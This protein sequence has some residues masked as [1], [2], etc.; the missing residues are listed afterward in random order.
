MCFKL[1]PFKIDELQQTKNGEFNV[2]TFLLGGN[3]TNYQEVN[4]NLKIQDELE[5]LNDS[6]ETEPAAQVLPMDSN[7]GTTANYRQSNKEIVQ[8]TLQTDVLGI[9]V[10]LLEEKNDYIANANVTTDANINSSH[11]APGRR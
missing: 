3:E 8:N 5:E 11:Q 2:H 1:S 4:Y 7:T 6:C 10:E 9:K